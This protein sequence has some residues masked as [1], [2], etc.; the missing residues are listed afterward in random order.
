M[1]LTAGWYKN[2]IVKNLFTVN[3]HK[4]LQNTR[5]PLNKKSSVLAGHE[6]TFRILLPST[7]PAPQRPHPIFSR[8]RTS[9]SWL[10][11]SPKLC[12][13]FRL[14]LSQSPALIARRVPKPPAVVGIRNL[15]QAC[16][17]PS[18]AAHTSALLLESWKK[19]APRIA[20]LHCQTTEMP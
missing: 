7:C 11:A 12:C 18:H 9:E 6:F 15:S 19:N 3:P 14:G 17:G 16:S 4:H 20:A 5:H 2:M 1:M 10:G 13:N 8:V